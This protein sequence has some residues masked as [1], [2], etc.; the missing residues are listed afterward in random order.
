MPDTAHLT[1]AQREQLAR[2]LTEIRQLVS[3]NQVEQALE[4]LMHFKP[5]IDPDDDLIR[6]SQRW[7]DNE[8][9]NQMNLIRREEYLLTQ[10]QV[11][12]ALLDFAGG[13]RQSVGPAAHQQED[14]ASNS[15]QPERVPTG[16]STPAAAPLVFLLY[17]PEDTAKVQ[18]LVAHL[19][20]LAR[21]NKIRLF[22]VEKDTNLGGG[23]TSSMIR[24]TILKSRLVLCFI[25]PHF[26]DQPYEWAELAQANGV[27]LAPIRLDSYDLEYSLFAKMVTLPRHG[28]PVSDWPNQD[29]AYTHVVEEVKRFLGL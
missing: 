13:L 1:D 27:A 20:P 10:N 25:T 8:R 26:M 5:G 22:D 14:A 28:G 2:L 29:A 6:L 4:K 9:Q 11:V 15:I 23:D 18:R 24:E 12:N 16:T 21:L 17:H 19:R 7:R 3:R